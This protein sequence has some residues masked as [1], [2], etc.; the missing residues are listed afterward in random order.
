MSLCWWKDRRCCG[1]SQGWK[2]PESHH[3]IHVLFLN[4]RCFPFDCLSSLPVNLESHCQYTFSHQAKGKETLNCSIGIT[5]GAGIRARLYCLGMCLGVPLS[6][7]L[8]HYF[9][10][11]LSLVISSL[12]HHF[13]VPQLPF[14]KLFQAFQI[15]CISSSIL[16]VA[17]PHGREPWGSQHSH[18][19]KKPAVL[20]ILVCTW[21]PASCLL[22]GWGPDCKIRVTVWDSP[23]KQLNFSKMETSDWSWKYQKICLPL[24]KSKLDHS[25]GLGLLVLAE[26]DVL[27]KIKIFSYNFRFL[28]KVLIPV[29][30]VDHK[31]VIGGYFIYTDPVDD[32]ICLKASRVSQT[33]EYIDT[34]LRQSP[35]FSLFIYTCIF[36]QKTSIDLVA[37][38][39]IL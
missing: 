37:I 13:L 32:D 24:K 4:K 8:M 23:K 2:V 20:K 6:P 34:F 35:F 29:S 38:L 5:A 30:W 27:P 31:W 7:H 12:P 1:G 18:E 9:P 15:Y 11:C 17:N 33:S 10:F 22:K 36:F 28:T 14:L 19:N 21:D 39:F 26:R 25:S 3:F 16:C